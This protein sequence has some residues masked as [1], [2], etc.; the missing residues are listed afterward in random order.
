M[1]AL[2]LFTVYSVLVILL[3]FALRNAPFR[4]IWNALAQLHLSQIAILFIIN[5][6]VILFITARWWIIVHA[7][8]PA[9]P[10]LP[11]IRYRL[12]VFGLSYFTPGPQVGGEPLQVL[13]LQRNHGI[14]FAR[15]TSAVIMDKLLEFLA[16]FILI[17]IGL[18]AAVRVGLISRNGTQAL[19]SLIPVAVV[20]LW[21]VVH[22]ILLYRGQYPI[23]NVLRCATSLIG[24]PNW[25]RLII[26]S[27]RMAAA[28]AHRRMKAL[29]LALGFS[30][31]AW[32]GMAAEY[33][34]M[35]SFLNANLSFEQTL[36][37][38]TAALF[39]F[40]L[41]LPG[42]LGALEASQVYALTTLGYTP[43]VGI[44]ISLIMRARDLLN[45][46]IGVLLAGNFI[47]EINS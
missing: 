23:S 20:L 29:L 21:P 36:A 34:L 10:F 18:A 47:R 2:H 19:G 27:E 37:A 42:G 9:V 3:Y 33:F 5:A 16:N 24:S 32:A 39:A 22:L 7:E 8:N 40:L 30:M 11:L 38:L 25:V 45:G 6:L 44:S 13:Y 46:G 17:G 26:V 14:S 1:R 43:A 12:S 31:L 28:F 41:P 35:A 15:A 4:E